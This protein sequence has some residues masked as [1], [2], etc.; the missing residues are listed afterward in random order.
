MRHSYPILD[1]KFA[2]SLVDIIA[3]ELNKNVNILDDQGMIIASFSKDRVGQLHEAGARILRTGN[4][5]EFSVTEHDELS[6]TGVRKGFNVPILYENRCVGIIG[7]TG[8]PDM[9]AP[10]ARLA[11]RFVEAALQANTRQEKL[12]KALREKRELQSIFLNQIIAV[13]EEERRKISRE[14]HDETSQALTSIIVGLRVLAEHIGQPEDKERILQ[15]RDLAVTTL[16]A[17]HHLAVEL[18]PVILDDLGFV[19]ATRK[20]LEHYSKQYG[21]DIEE[22]FANLP[23]V[24]LAPDIEIN[25]YRILQEALTNIAKHAA[26]TRVKVSLQKKRSTLVFYIEDNG[27]GFDINAVKRQQARTCLGLY[28]M[29]ERVA[30]LAGEIDIQT[31]LG[32][33]TRIYVSIPLAKPKRQAE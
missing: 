4:V 14:L 22:N 27:N 13:Q 29:K 6:L 3:A 9:A 19:A 17:V 11:A 16:E 25:L 8:Q 23:K 15:M 20:Y 30:L 2:Q 18:R 32:G 31:K 24:R 12:V 1:H 5:Q 28:G 33:G 26:A 7:V 10:Y 21:I